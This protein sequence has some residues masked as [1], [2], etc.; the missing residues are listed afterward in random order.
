MCILAAFLSGLIV[1][2]IL[3]A[4]ASNATDKKIEKNGVWT[5]GGNAYRLTRIEP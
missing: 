1:A 5:T 2:F 3:F 4:M